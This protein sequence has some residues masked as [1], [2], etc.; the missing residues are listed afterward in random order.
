VA[1]AGIWAWHAG[2]QGPAELEDVASRGLPSVADPPDPL[3]DRAAESLAAAWDD[4]AGDRP[5]RPLPAVTDPAASRML[6][7]EAVAVAVPLSD[8][9]ILSFEVPTE[10][11]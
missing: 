3:R 9:P 2:R 7:E 11:E 1:V 6:A 8:D 4:G 10:A 5:L